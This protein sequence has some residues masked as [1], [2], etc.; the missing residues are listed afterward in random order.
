MP[1]TVL[2]EDNSE[3][4]QLEQDLTLM[5]CMLMTEEMAKVNTEQMIRAIHIKISFIKDRLS[6]LQ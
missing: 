1:V 5:Q 4:E 2:M 3:R 6:Q